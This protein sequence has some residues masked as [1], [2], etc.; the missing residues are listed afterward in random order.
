MTTTDFNNKELILSK[1]NLKAFVYDYDRGFLNDDLIGYTALNLN[2]LI[3]RSDVSVE[4][5][6]EDKSLNKSEYL[7][8]ISLDLSLIPKY[9]T[10]EKELVSGFNH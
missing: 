10:D 3:D 9:K 7:G 4:M 6:L 8:I 5:E 2:A 1:Y